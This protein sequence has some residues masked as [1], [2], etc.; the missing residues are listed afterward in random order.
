MSCFDLI[1]VGGGLAGASLAVALRDSRLR[2]ALVEY[3]PPR[4][5]DG[6][7]ARIYAVSPANVEFLRDI[8]VW[9]HLD[10]ARITPIR[11]MQ[12]FGDGGGELNFS[13]F[14]TAVPDLGCIL[15]SSLMACELWESL[16]RQGNASRHPAGN[17]NGYDQ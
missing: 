9:K 3:Q 12:V 2:I 5:S 16:K 1:I 14:D 4:R 11:A 10:A 6:W 13:A 17:C 8:G 15:E 7:D